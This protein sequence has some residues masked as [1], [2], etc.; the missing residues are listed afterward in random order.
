MDFTKNLIPSKQKG[1]YF[2]SHLPGF[3][4]KLSEKQSSL[5][6][7]ALKT[8][9]EWQQKRVCYLRTKLKLDVLREV[10]EESQVSRGYQNLT[11]HEQQKLT[12]INNIVRASGNRS[13]DGLVNNITHKHKVDDRIN[14]MIKTEMKMKILNTC[15][16]LLSHYNSHIEVKGTSSR[17]TGTLYQKSLDLV[18][19]I[20]ND[21]HC[22]DNVTENKISKFD[23][24]NE[25]NTEKQKKQRLKDHLSVLN[26]IVDTHLIG[27]VPKANDTNVEHLAAKVRN[28]KS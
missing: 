21:I 17:D 6:D 18:N 5:H 2:E 24:R 1:E 26:Q 11:Q 8:H 16:E 12:E 15:S 28:K 25:I 22:I 13:F 7:S 4:T 20:K 3:V 9:K 27:S 10:I 23:D 19:L 14:D